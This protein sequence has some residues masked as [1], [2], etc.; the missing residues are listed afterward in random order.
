LFSQKLSGFSETDAEILVP[1]AA[2][3]AA[4]ENVTD[5]RWLEWGEILLPRLAAQVRSEQR[6]NQG[7]FSILHKQ[8]SDWF[9]DGVTDAEE[10]ESLSAAIPVSS[11]NLSLVSLAESRRSE[12]F[13]DLVHHSSPT[14]RAATIQ[15]MPLE[16]VTPVEDSLPTAPSLLDRISSPNPNFVPSP[17]SSPSS[18]SIPPPYKSNTASQSADEIILPA[19]EDD[20][21]PNEDKV[22]DAASVPNVPKK[23]A[24]RDLPVLPVKKRKRV[25]S[26]PSASENDSDS[27]DVPIVKSKPAPKSSSRRS[28]RSRTSTTLPIPKTV[29]S[30][31]EKKPAPPLKVVT[32]IV[33]LLPLPPDPKVFLLSSF[34]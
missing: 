4:F 23:V 24:S 9:I 22:H 11:D 14:I 15:I 25:I 7:L 8:L 31:K 32:K 17:T 13:D 20:N 29:V 5:R 2:A 34:S 27:I 26:S 6:A 28:S 3:R 33:K 21:L 1:L 19:A 12:A 30:S 18:V 16:E 10:H